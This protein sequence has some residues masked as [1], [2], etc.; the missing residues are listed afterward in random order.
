MHLGLG[1]FFRAHQA[2]YTE[3][4]PDAGDWGIAAFSGRSADLPNQLTAQEGLYTLITRAAEGDRF[5]VV[6]SLSAAYP[7][8]EHEAW[9]D[10]LASSDV[11][12]VT[13]TVT[14]AGYVRSADGGLDRDRPEV[15]QDV[16]ALRRDLAAP[17]RTTPARLLAGF[18]ARRRSDA[19]P[20]ALVP[21]DNVAGNG[22]IAVGVVRDLAEMVDPQLA[23]WCAE[24]VSKVTTMVDRITPRT[25]PG[26]ER[27]VAEGPGWID[28]APV[29]TEPFAEWVLSG[30]FPA[31]RP[32]WQ[33]AGARFSDDI[34]PFEHRKLWLLNGAHSLLAY[35]GS[36]RGHTTVAEAVTDETCRSWMQQWWDEAV[37][38]LDLPAADLQTYREALVTRFAN[39][40]IR[41][42]L[43]QIATDG[44]QKLPERILPVV[45]E[46]RSTG[47][48]P[49]GAVRVLAAWV[50]HL[51]GHGVPVADPRADELTRRAAGPLP[52]A[53]RRVLDTLD[54]H[55]GADGELVAAVAADAERLE[56]E[57]GT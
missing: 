12:A 27:I 37:A 53:A 19:G 31:G 4:A 36:I 22:A 56:R 24:H 11:A 30:A 2:W 14:E 39:P 46:E 35:A 47:R 6:G 21:C 52:D 15:R 26:D 51:R 25:D 32:S 3:H 33:D 45:A 8:G 23:D 48:M 13:V 40:R 41:H 16:D 18:A 17:V 55:V 54:P 49:E 28:R 5:E 38:H 1:N 43:A 9:L 50:C 29:A 34:V 44:S 42:S 7:G 57:A 20:I 10:H